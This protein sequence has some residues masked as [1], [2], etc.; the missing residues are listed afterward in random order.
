MNIRWNPTSSGIYNSWK[1]AS[2]TNSQSLVTKLFGVKS[3][4]GA[5]AVLNLSIDGDTYTKGMSV[6]TT[7]SSSTSK[8]TTKAN[9]NVEA[10]LEKFKKNAASGTGMDYE[11]REDEDLFILSTGDESISCS[12]KQLQKSLNYD[13]PKTME[14]DGNTIT[15]EDNSY[16]KFTDS[17][18]KEHKV[19]SLCG[20]LLEGFGCD[21][22]EEASEYMDFWNC[23]AREDPTY[24]PLNFSDTKVR[25]TLGDLG[26]QTGFY[27]INVGGRTQTQY[28]SQ[29][30]NAAA[31]YSKE[32]YDER[33]YYHI[34][35]G[36]LTKNYVAGAVIKIGGV[37]YTVD[38]N[39]KI[40]SV[41]YGADIWDI[42][43]PGK[44]W[45]KH[46]QSK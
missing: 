1:N 27:T 8:G 14:V 36:N 35:S 4:Q 42:E 11:I 30:K 18:G 15:F 43:Y 44:E 28:L 29:G 16:Y 45:N 32:Q 6:T 19:L 2:I 13:N 12:Y 33:Y 41:P 38:E 10:V 25:N 37:E 31:I 17:S 22:D 40:P 5:N 9:S 3:K 34:Q 26:I 24:V 23:M 7:K 39:G 20:K 21:Y 46:F